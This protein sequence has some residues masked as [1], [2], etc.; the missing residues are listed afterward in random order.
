MQ[1]DARPHLRAVTLGALRENPLSA[2]G[3]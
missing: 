1:I 3:G 2:T